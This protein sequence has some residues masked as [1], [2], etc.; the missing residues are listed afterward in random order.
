MSTAARQK[1]ADGIAVLDA[2]KILVIEDD[3]STRFLLGLTLEQ[4]REF[5][6]IWATCVAEGK[7]RFAENQVDLIVC[8]QNMGDGFGTEVLGLS[9]NAILKFLLFFLRLNLE[10][11]FLSWNLSSAATF[12]NL[13]SPHCSLKSRIT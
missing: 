11:I 2:P 4:Q 3:E 5:D 13:R 10:T 8:D 6:L 7:L 12:R 9:A 1:L